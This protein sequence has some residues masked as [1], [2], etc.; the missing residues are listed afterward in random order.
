MKQVLGLRTEHP[1]HDEGTKGGSQDEPGV[2]KK[3]QVGIQEL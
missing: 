2:D 1:R 3:K